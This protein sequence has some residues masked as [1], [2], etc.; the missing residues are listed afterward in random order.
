VLR[1][2]ELGGCDRVLIG[3]DL[4]QLDAAIVSELTRQPPDRSAKVA[5]ANRWS[6]A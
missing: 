1:T 3:S 2:V 6:M 5:A 4:R